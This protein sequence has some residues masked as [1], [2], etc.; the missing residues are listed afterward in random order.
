MKVWISE[1]QPSLLD[2]IQPPRTVSTLGRR[3]SAMSAAERAA[4]DAWKEA[5]TAFILE[6][7]ETHED[8]TGEDIRIAYD[9][10]DKPQ[11]A[12]SKRA[13]GAIFMRLARTGMILQVGY[14][15]SALYGNQLAVYRRQ[16]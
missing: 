16:R 8:S 13:S 2:G 11:S 4:S 1:N 6:Y 3:Y 10:T 14:R 12:N 9:K 15:R 5:Y 7:L